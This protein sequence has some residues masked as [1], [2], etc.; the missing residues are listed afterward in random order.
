MQIEESVVK[1]ANRIPYWFKEEVPK[2]FQNLQPNER[3]K[4]QRIIFEQRILRETANSYTNCLSVLRELLECWQQLGIEVELVINII[5]RLRNCEVSKD[6][7]VEMCKNI[8]DQMCLEL[9][10][11]KREFLCSFYLCLMEFEFPD[12]FFKKESQFGSMG[13]YAWLIL[14]SLY[15]EM[16]RILICEAKF[17]DGFVFSDEKTKENLAIFLKQVINEKPFE[18]QKNYEFVSNVLREV[19]AALNHFPSDKLMP[20]QTLENI[21]QWTSQFKLLFTQA[22]MR[23][24]LRRSTTLENTQKY[25]SS[26]LANA[27]STT[28]KLIQLQLLNQ[29]IVFTIAAAVQETLETFLQNEIVLMTPIRSKKRSSFNFQ[30]RAALLNVIAIN[31][32]TISIATSDEAVL[33][34]I[35]ELVNLSKICAENKIRLGTRILRII[36]EPNF[37]FLVFVKCFFNDLEI[38]NRLITEDALGFEMFF[39]LAKLLKKKQTGSEMQ[40]KI[41]E[42]KV[43]FLLANLRS[44]IEKSSKV[45]QFNVKPLLANL[46]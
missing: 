41:E 2:R 4:I 20:D 6:N 11:D 38:I 19:Y 18:T 15:A 27:L 3:E 42:A 43:T 26:T 28:L 9:K 33:H 30:L 21:F 35:S 14:I 34:V 44:L 25:K 13:K 12:C 5:N 39:T 10:G 7:E 31:L 22:L 17:K 16:L 40:D 45:L 1:P 37:I 29:K 46:P 24:P 32:K 23:R 36:T 8:D